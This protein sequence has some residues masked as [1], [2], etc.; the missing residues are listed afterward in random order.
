MCQG[1]VCVKGWFVYT[2]DKDN[3]SAALGAVLFVTSA[4]S[5]Y[6][7]DTLGSPLPQFLKSWPQV[8]SAVM[9]VQPFPEK[10]WGLVAT[11]ATTLSIQCCAQYRWWTLHPG[12]VQDTWGL[13]WG[14]LA[15][16][17]DW[18][19]YTVWNGS[20]QSLNTDCVPTS[21]RFNPLVCA[22][23]S[24]LLE[25]QWTMLQVRPH[26]L[27]I[28]SAVFW[29]GFGRLIE[30]NHMIVNASPATPYHSVQLLSQLLCLL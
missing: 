18:G 25:G 7:G 9:H 5:P 15:S 10:T 23:L 24:A 30:Y 1:V 20:C 16:C 12:V 17:A 14:W 3:C 27:Y 13:L 19:V 28:S 4:C 29:Y 2:E 11:T 6:L 8:F 21:I 26:P 22:T